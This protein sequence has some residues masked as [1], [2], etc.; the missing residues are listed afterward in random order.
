MS[1]TAIFTWIQQGQVPESVAELATAAKA[2][3]E[4][5]ACYAF[6]AD[7]DDSLAADLSFDG[8]DAV[9]LVNTPGLALCQSDG[10]AEAAAQVMTADGLTTVLL[11]AEPAG[12]DIMSRAAVKV[13]AGMTSDCTALEVQDGAIRQIKPSFGA[14]VMVACEVKGAPEIITMKKG[15]TAPADK[16]AAAPCDV[17]TVEAASK[18]TCGKITALPSSD[19][20]TGADVVVVAGKGAIESGQFETVKAYAD[21]IGAALAGSRPV[22]DQG[23]IPFDDQIGESGTVIQPKLCIIFGVSGAIQFTEGIKGDGTVI[24]VNN[25][26][27]A[28]IRGFADVFICADMGE[29]LVAM[30]AK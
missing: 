8:I 25:D 15:S 10:L 18:I 11:E 4:T 20:L 5:A 17:R 30:N 28:P 29:L 7:L 21:K 22:A 16:T 3:G 24:A 27:N 2:L 9:H 26:P 6:G 1:K 12:R 14:Q 13:G 23:F 19:H